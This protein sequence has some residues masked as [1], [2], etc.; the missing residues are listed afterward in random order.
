MIEETFASK[1]PTVVY[2]PTKWHS[3]R[4]VALARARGISVEE[5]TRRDEIVK[6]LAKTVEVSLYGHG[7]PKAKKEFDT[8]GE[9]VVTGICRTY[10]DFSKAEGWP[11]NDN[12]MIVSF[13]ALKDKSKNYFCTANYLVKENLHAEIVTC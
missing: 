7:F 1:R 13:Y 9:V 11:D 10:A 2:T 3:A 6:E 12:P 8:L 5:F 4:D